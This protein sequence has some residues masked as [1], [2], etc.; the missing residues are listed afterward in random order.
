MGFVYRAAIPTML[1][2]A[3]Q[4][5]IANDSKVKQPS[6]YNFTMADI[7]GK[8]VALSRY[9]GRVLLIVNVASK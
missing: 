8:D 1:A 3:T 5:A 2:C 7:N 6:V 9:Q 4:P